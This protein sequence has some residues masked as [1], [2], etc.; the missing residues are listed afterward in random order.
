ME[1]A[2]RCDRRGVERNR[3]RYRG[4]RWPCCNECRPRCERYSGASGSSG[5]WPRN[6]VSTKTPMSPISFAQAWRH[7]RPKRRAAIEFAGAEALK[8]ELRAARG[9]RLIDELL[10]DLRY[11]LR[12]LRRGRGFAVVVVLALGVG[13]NLAVFSVVYAALIRPLPHPHPERLV[14][15]SSRDLTHD[16]DHLTSPLDSSMSNGVHHRSS[17]WGRTLSARVHAYWQWPG[18]ARSRRT[19]QFGRVRRLRRASGTRA[20]FPPGGGRVRCASG[21]G[22]Q[23]W[24]VDSA[25]PA[26]DVHHRANH[27]AEWQP[28]HGRRSPA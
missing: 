10:Q 14:S 21:G 13:A 5:R 19:C 1:P 8:E 23:P 9:L 11:S 15:I 16:R 22:H 27:R 2:G 25:I 3:R 24:I 26:V 4:V 18:G 6:C 7:T 28:V 17:A 20:W 12:Q